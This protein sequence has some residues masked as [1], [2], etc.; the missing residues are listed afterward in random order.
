MSSANLVSITYVRETVYGTPDTPLSGVTAETARFT[1]ETLSGTPDTAE[2]V[3]IRTDRS[4]SGLVVTGLTVGGDINIELAAGTFY[5]DFIEAAMM[6]D[7]V[8]A[9]SQSG[10]I[11]LTPIDDY[12]AT[13]TTD[14][15]MTTIGPG[16]AVGD[17]IQIVP[18]TG[19]SITVTVIS[20]E[21][22]TSCTVATKT[23]QAAYGPSTADLTIAEYVIVGSKQI[24]NSFTIGKA[25]KDVTHLATT[26]EHSQT[27]AGSYVSGFNVA[28]TYGE[29]TNGTFNTVANGYKLENPSMEQQIVTAG[30]TVNPAATTQSLN[31]S[32]DVPLVVTNGTS[33]PYCIESINLTLDNGMEPSNC[34]GSV[35]PK[36]Y[37]LGQATI[38][39]DV[40]TYLS[41]PSYDAY[42][43]NKLSQ[44]PVSIGFQRSNTDG[45]YF[46][47]MP[48]VQLTFPDPS[49][50]GINEQTMLDASGT[51]S[52]GPNGESPL[53]IS[54]LV[55][56]Q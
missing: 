2:S 37:T 48:S 16:V 18:A 5:E 29:I 1:S 23:G 20:V 15:D 10:S 11:T 47:Q 3:N 32:V 53:K 27:Y 39:V 34:L 45:G 6:G 28:A 42:Q 33:A 31:A 43:P 35:A 26:D 12:T 17:V 21:S 54:K 46:F 9:E 50:D 8:P 19:P 7:W 14:G 30:G 52:A 41:D 25:Y 36:N 44:V 56:D 24:G 22:T 51:A 4:S 40:S 38:T 55:G 13:L 49:A